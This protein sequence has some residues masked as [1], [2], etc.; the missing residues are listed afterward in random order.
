MLPIPVL[1]NNYAQNF[2]ASLCLYFL[3]TCLG[4]DSRV[5]YSM[6]KFVETIFIASVQLPTVWKVKDQCQKSLL[7]L[8]KFQQMNFYFP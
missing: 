8:R 5:V 6:S 4:I 7:I 1:Q 3:E 2:I